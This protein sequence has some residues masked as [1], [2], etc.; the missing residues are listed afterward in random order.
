[1]EKDDFFQFWAYCLYKSEAG[2][3][4]CHVW[5]LSLML[6]DGKEADHR[7]CWDAKVDPFCPH[8]YWAPR[9]KNTDPGVSWLLHMHLASPLNHEY[10]YLGGKHATVALK[11]E[12][13]GPAL[14]MWRHCNNNSRR[15]KSKT[16]THTNMKPI[17]IIH[18]TKVYTVHFVSSHTYSIIYRYMYIDR[19]NIMIIYLHTSHIYS[20]KIRSVYIFS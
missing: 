1:M 20:H 11:V 10:F 2:N 8:C 4:V 9:K 14:Q 5:W 13:W 3:S 16:H 18:R 12:W 19:Y 7:C 6:H 17:H 15:Y